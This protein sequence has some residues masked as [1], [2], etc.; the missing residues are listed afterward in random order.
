MTCVADRIESGSDEIVVVANNTQ[1]ALKLAIFAGFVDVE[2]RRT[3]ACI[4]IRCVYNVRTRIVVVDAICERY[5]ARLAS[6][7]VWRCW[8][9]EWV[10]CRD[11]NSA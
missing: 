2:L 6:W 8:C 3:F 7:R 11:S 9:Q 10:E 4:G 5:V 1:A